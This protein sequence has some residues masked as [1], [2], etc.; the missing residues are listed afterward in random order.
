MIPALDRYHFGCQA[1]S[2]IRFIV[3]LFTNFLFDKN[4]TFLKNSYFI[5]SSEFVLLLKISFK[6]ES[7]M[8]HIYYI[9]KKE[10]KIRPKVLI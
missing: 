2:N 10:D 3:F 7:Y 5:I 9:I 6:Y 4:Y 8:I 1:T